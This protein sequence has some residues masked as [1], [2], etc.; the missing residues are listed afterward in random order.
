MEFQLVLFGLLS[1][2][3]TVIYVMTSKKN[4]Q[5]E[6]RK[7]QSNSRFRE[8]VLRK[9]LEK[10]AE[11]RVKYSKRYEIETLCLQA[12]FKLQFVEYLMLSM[13]S[14]VVFAILMMMAMNNVLLGIVFLFI[15]YMVPKQAITFV[16]N[17]RVA[18]MDKQIGSFMLM[19]LK[20][21][22][23]TKDFK[24]SLELTMKEFRGEEPL[25]SEIRQTVMDTNLGKPITEALEEM[26]RRT[27]N[28]YMMRLS[29]YYKISS[30]IG[31]DDARK[32]LLNQA[33]LQ[34]EENR[35][36][37]SLMK[38]ELSSVKRESY[39]MLGAVPVF[40]LFQANTNED[41]IRFMTQESMGQIGT[42]VIFV[43]LSGAVWFINNKISAPL[44]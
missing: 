26:A 5:L 41:Y 43:V 32:K 28:K 23:N 21:Y 24:M 34:Y 10:L 44:D 39:I 8:N 13:A 14:S 36:A 9:R 27:G 25:Y 38:R 17:R 6:K 3:I 20:R 15:G 22:E 33:F 31:T 37:K 19:I 1:F 30:E 7:Q 42:L 18:M 12:G 2:L 35:K 29:D 4:D 11:D 40:A 16:K